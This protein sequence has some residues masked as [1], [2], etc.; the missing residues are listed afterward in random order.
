[1][2]VNQLRFNP[3]KHDTRTPYIHLLAFSNCEEA[4]PAS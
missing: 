2:L 1:V 4:I 3:D